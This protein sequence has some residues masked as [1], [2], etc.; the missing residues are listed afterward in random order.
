[1]LTFELENGKCQ[2]LS[3]APCNELLNVRFG[4]ARVLYFMGYWRVSRAET[5]RV[6]SRPV[7]PSQVKSSQVK[8]SQVKILDIVLVA[9]HVSYS[10]SS[11]AFCCV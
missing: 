5:S 2:R 6:E 8:S 1:M 10:N 3:F 9:R 7:K 4:G 11:V